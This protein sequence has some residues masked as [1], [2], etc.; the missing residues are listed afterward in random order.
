IRLGHAVA[1]SAC[2]P[3]LFDPIELHGLYP[4]RTVRL[5]DGG[6]HD[7]QGMVGLMEQEC[8]AVVVSD[9]SGQMNSQRVPSAEGLLVPLRSNSILMGR[10]REQEFRELEALR[11]VSALSGLLF[12][13]LKKDLDTNYVDW[14]DCPV[15]HGAFDEVLKKRGTLTSYN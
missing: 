10:V 3:A 12:L 1:A 8:A 4:K 2:V 13:H 15:P 9:A 11:N 14:V 5:V 7:N 6:V